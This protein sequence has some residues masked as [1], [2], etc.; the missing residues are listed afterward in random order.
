M[1]ES[2]RDHLAG[3]MQCESL[4][5]CFH[6]L[7]ALDREVFSALV[8]AADPL[9]VDEVAE[10]VDRER[11]TA[12]RSVR[13]LADAGFVRSTQIN[14]EDGGY[15]HV[16]EPVDADEVTADLQRMLDD[17]YALMDRLIDEFEA[18][19]TERDAARATRGPQGGGGGAAGTE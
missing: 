13:R 10:A 16:Y 8:E 17:W 12:Y 14:Y 7:K 3:D 6:G 2:V 19:Y 1:S 11:S 9:T 15:Y 18:K 4:L 5:E